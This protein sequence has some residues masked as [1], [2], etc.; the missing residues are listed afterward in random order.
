MARVRGT[1]TVPVVGAP[2]T[3]HRVGRTVQGAVDSG[4]SGNDG[5]FRFRLTADTT[6]L[7]LVSA[8]HDGIEYFGDP[9]R[10]PGTDQALVL[11]SDT[12]STV[13]VSLS[14]RHVIIRRP[15]PSG[16]RAVLDLLSIR[17]DGPETRVGA[18]TLTPTW[19]VPLPAGATGAEIQEGDISPSAVRFH[20]DTLYLFAPI[21]PGRKNVMVGYLLPAAVDRPRWTAP[22]D[23]FD[24]LVEEEGASVRGAGLAPAEPVT[25]MG[26]A[27]LRWT[28]A[29]PRGAIGEVRFAGGVTV[30]RRILTVLVGLLAV[31]LAAGAAAAFGRVGRRT[32][33]AGGAPPADL[34]GELAR[35]DARFEGGRDAV[36]E[37]EWAAYQVERTRLK[38]AAL[39]RR[40]RRP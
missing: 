12:S 37:V 5:R 3:L 14:A 26:S 24:L 1:D 27:L 8:S 31:A 13:P 39:A 19:S 18:D 36:G 32:T 10:A 11:V 21:A 20:G 28:A 6:S 40:R 33:H 34:V 15:D 9:I 22:G 25:L 17:N 2:L 23:S 30:R 7:Y 29:P 38:A 35:L 4:S 16:S